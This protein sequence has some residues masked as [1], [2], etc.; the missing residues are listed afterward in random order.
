MIISLSSKVFKHQPKGPNFLTKD[1]VTELKDLSYTTRAKLLVLVFSGE[2]N[3]D[4]LAQVFSKVK[5][6]KIDELNIWTN[7]VF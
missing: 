7:K 6:K 5:V 4:Q 1:V 2:Q 3:F